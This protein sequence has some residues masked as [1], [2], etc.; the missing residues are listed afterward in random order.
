MSL[1]ALNCWRSGS[2]E[3]LRTATGSEAWREEL[4]S[5]LE[6]QP[7]PNRHV[8]STIIAALENHG[9]TTHSC[10][11]RCSRDILGN[12]FP[13]EMQILIFITDSFKINP[14]PCARLQGQGRTCEYPRCERQILL[15]L[16]QRHSSQM[17][18]YLARLQPPHVCVSS[19]KRKICGLAPAVCL[20]PY[21]HAPSGGGNSSPYFFP[22]SITRGMSCCCC[23]LSA[24]ISSKNPSKPDGVMTHMSRPGVLPR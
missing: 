7:A 4:C 6:A 10:S 5:R 16:P 20:N 19:L 13:Y 1:S 17:H 9:A 12:L 22:I 14:K 18:A 21:L 8:S 15:F 2:I 23:G 11:F 3:S 24:P